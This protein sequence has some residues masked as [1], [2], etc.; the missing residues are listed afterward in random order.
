MDK[1]LVVLCAFAFGS[2]LAVADD[3]DTKPL[4]K[5]T[6]EE[7]QAARSAAKAQW[8]KMK[9]EEKAAVKKGI[10][11]KRVEA[12]TALETLAAEEGPIGPIYSNPEIYSNRPKLQWKDSTECEK[13]QYAGLTPNGGAMHPVA[14][15]PG[16]LRPP[17]A[18]RE[19]DLRQP[20]E[21]KQHQQ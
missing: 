10:L 17:K 5:M 20:K 11:N 9:P 4:S 13:R 12:L 7:A 19:A 2:A 16:D 21:S 1:L 3:L 18:E 6:A 14:C 15:P 8:K